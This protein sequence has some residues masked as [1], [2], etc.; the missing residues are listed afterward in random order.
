MANILVN[1]FSAKAGGGKAILENYLALLCGA[2]HAK[3][4]RYFVLTPNP[5]SY[6]GCAT[7]HVQIVPVPSLYSRGPAF[8]P[9]FYL[10]YVPGIV[11]CLDI[12]A[13]LN[14]G[15]IILPVR[16]P[17][18]YFFD[19]PY[20]A[21]PD[22]VV[23]RRMRLPDYA[24][25]RLKLWIVRRTLRY[26]TR[27]IVQI[28]TMAQRLE[29]L[30]GLRNIVVIPS[31]VTLES[32]QAAADTVFNL[33]GGRRL[34]LCPAGFSPHKNIPVLLPVARLLAKARSDVS[35]VT[36]LDPAPNSATRRFIASVAAAE[37]GPYL[38]NIGDVPRHRMGALY[39]R[40]DG[41][42]L[43]TLLESYGLPFVEAMHNR[44]TVLTS[45]YPFTRD[46]CGD[47]AF[48]FDPLDADSIVATIQD[49]FSDES[50]RQAKI[51]QGRALV[52]R[53]NTWPEAFQAYQ[54]CIAAA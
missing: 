20:A 45:D 22:S 23:W 53:I 46:V 47:A 49:A 10:F 1:G 50:R 16:V 21:Y 38:V 28:P 32:R 6:A 24:A 27:T 14:F 8:L 44:R 31:P 5:R 12:D 36:T 15:D 43:P 40:C 4:D 35:I 54:A 34:L 18:V 3:T 51:E 52:E 29:R 17:Q 7:D 13:I 42:L 2:T 30:Y 33:P 37:L 19:W 39:Q 25:R 48:Y 11:R 9:F 26:A 41:L